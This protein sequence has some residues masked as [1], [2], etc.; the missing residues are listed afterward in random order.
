MRNLFMIIC[1]ALIVYG[2]G[3][4]TPPKSKYGILVFPD[5]FSGSGTPVHI[6]YRI[7]GPDIKTIDNLGPEGTIKYFDLIQGKSTSITTS[8]YEGSN[9]GLIVSIFKL[10]P[11]STTKPVVQQQGQGTVTVRFKVE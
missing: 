6:K 3:K 10:L 4:D 7:S 1:V 5:L 9:R 2:C 11:D 8:I